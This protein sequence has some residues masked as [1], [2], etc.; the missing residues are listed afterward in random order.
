MTPPAVTLVTVGDSSTARFAVPGFPNSFLEDATSVCWAAL[1]Q[2]AIQVHEPAAEVVVISKNGNTTTSFLPDGS[3]GEDPAH[4]VT[5]CMTYF[6]AAPAFLFIQFQ[7]NP[8]NTVAQNITNLQ[9]AKAYA[10][11]F[12]ATVYVLTP[13]P[14]LSSS[15]PVIDELLD[16]VTQVLSTFGAS[17]IDMW[18]PFAALNGRD[19]DPAYMIGGDDTLHWNEAGHALAFALVQAATGLGT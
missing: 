19:A 12:G 5:R 11:G 18:T 15:D 4:N 13:H 2:T 7:V 9:T 6:G 17:A 14:V 3:G 16:Q 10:E 8:P 1:L